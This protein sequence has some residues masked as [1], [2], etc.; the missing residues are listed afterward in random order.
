MTNQE[1][2]A[3]AREYAEEENPIG[4]YGDNMF[5]RGMDLSI[6][7]GEAERVLTWLTHRYYL[8]EKSKVENIYKGILVQQDP[9]NFGY[10]AYNQG[11][12]EL[13]KSIFPEIGKEVEE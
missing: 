9:K 12:K 7:R 5:E 3:L 10:S 1:I 6:S 11:K 2:T 8:V 4:S 13:L